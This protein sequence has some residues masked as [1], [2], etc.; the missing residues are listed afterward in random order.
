MRK[1]DAIPHTRTNHSPCCNTTS[2]FRSAPTRGMST[3]HDFP[4]LPTVV[5]TTSGLCCYK[6]WDDCAMMGHVHLHR[7]SD[8]AR[9]AS[10]SEIQMM[11]PYASVLRGLLPKA[12]TSQRRSKTTHR[13][14]GASSSPGDRQCSPSHGEHLRTLKCRCPDPHVPPVPHPHPDP[15]NR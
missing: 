12:L 15:Q 11:M 5:H 13:Q 7:R 3:G 6:L 4:E 14:R 9:I 10:T 2:I 1:A 8:D